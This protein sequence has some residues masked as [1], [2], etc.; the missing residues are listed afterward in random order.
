MIKKLQRQ[1]G[2]VAEQS[3]VDGYDQALQNMHDVVGITQEVTRVLGPSEGLTYLLNRLQEQ[4]IQIGVPG[5]P[6]DW[7]SRWKVELAP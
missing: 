3:L 1:L 2:D 7:L 5:V 6:Y 4:D